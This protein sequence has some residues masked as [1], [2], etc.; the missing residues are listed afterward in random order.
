M[1]IYLVVRKG[2]YAIFGVYD[3]IELVRKAVKKA[4]KLHYDDDE[5]FLIYKTNL[6]Q[7]KY[8]TNYIEE[9]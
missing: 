8:I 4:R 2:P 6:N 3:D 7:Y 5:V 1:E 9:L